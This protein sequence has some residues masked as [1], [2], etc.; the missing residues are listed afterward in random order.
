MTK[1]K[2]GKGRNSRREPA[3]IE[4]VD[5]RTVRGGAGVSSPPVSGSGSGTDLVSNFN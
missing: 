1:T 3:T 2:T 5:L 4:M